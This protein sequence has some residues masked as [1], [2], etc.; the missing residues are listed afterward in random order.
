[1]VFS[2]QKV[3]WFTWTEYAISDLGRPEAAADFFNYGIILS[4]VLLLIFSLGL[5]RYL[6]EKAG[7]TMLGLSSSFF[8]GIGFF[9]L[10]DPNHTMVSS[11]FFIGFLLS[12]FILGVT[13]Y[14]RLSRFVGRMGAFAL[15]IAGVSM[16]TPLLLLFYEG[17]A[18]PELLIVIPGFFWCMVM[19]FYMMVG[20]ETA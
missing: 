20:N 17:I 14:L 15:I 2:I 3:S 6:N 19:G 4:G 11:L 13:L 10:P 5:I 16:C 1:L 12:L 7:P 9:P 8:I 18:L